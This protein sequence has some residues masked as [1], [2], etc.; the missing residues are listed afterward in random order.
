[1]TVATSGS[2]A[3]VTRSL[4]GAGRSRYGIRVPRTRAEQVSLQEAVLP[5]T[6]SV[7]LSALLSTAPRPPLAT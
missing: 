3:W 5:P 4:N 6:T 2:R 7:L 1:V